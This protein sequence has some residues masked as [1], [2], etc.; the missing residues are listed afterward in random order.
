VEK[1][2][3]IIDFRNGKISETF[4]ILTF[5]FSNRILLIGTPCLKIAGNSSSLVATFFGSAYCSF[6][7]LF[8]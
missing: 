7:E 8:Y 3:I 2:I 5:D 4:N 6:L 1:A